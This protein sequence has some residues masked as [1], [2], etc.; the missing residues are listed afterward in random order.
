[1]ENK[2]QKAIEVLNNKGII[3][4]PT[5]TVMGIGCRIDSEEALRRLFEIKKRDFSQAVPVLVSSIEMVKEY[6]S[7]FPK[8]VEELM[9]K[10]LPGG[11]TVVLPCKKEKVLPLIRG[12]GDTIGL[13]IPDYPMIRSI[14][15]NLNTPIVGTSANFHGK[16]SAVKAEDLDEEL[17]KLVD[18][19]VPGD[20]LGGQ[21]STV[22]DCSTENWKILRQGAVKVELKVEEK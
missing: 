11:L 17:I 20:A 10:Y 3:I 16:P 2:I 21:S 13:R 18:Y 14:I 1:M 19:V 12:N 22:I 7:T 8:R 9:E 4:F 6:V 5:D 15:E